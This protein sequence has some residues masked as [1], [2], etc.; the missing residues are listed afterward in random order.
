M[1]Y[2]EAVDLH[3]ND[4][5]EKS[6]KLK[7]EILQF[8]NQNKSK[9]DVEYLISEEF[10]F[11]ISEFNNKYNMSSPTALKGTPFG[12]QS[13][14]NSISVYLDLVRYPKSLIESL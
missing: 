8:F 11:K 2:Q 1:T 6:E 5:T 9:E 12:H 13:F 7:S 10:R 14:S 4:I 3:L